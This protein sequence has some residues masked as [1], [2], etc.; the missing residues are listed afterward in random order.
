[1]RRQLLPPGAARVGTNRHGFGTPASQTRAR[2]A[3]I[4]NAEGGGTAS[5]TLGG[6]YR[7]VGPF[8]VSAGDTA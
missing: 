3:G 7:V 5:P 2:P 4:V 1:V 8:G 6:G